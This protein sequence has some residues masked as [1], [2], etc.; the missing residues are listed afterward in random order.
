M[1][2]GPENRFID[3]VHR[4]LKDKCHFEKMHN[5]YRGGTADVW[6]SGPCADI[7]VEYKWRNSVPKRGVAKP[8]LEPLQRDWLRDRYTEG[9]KVFVIIGT[10]AGGI[11]FATPEAWERGRAVSQITIR[12]KKEIAD[13]V[14]DHVGN[15]TSETKDE[16]GKEHK[17]RPNGDVVDLQ[18]RSDVVHAVRVA[19]VRKGKAP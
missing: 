11:I 6:Y 3:S 13:W 18:D 15:Y 17:R 1:S 10:P 12:P 14:R 5:P 8:K 4:Y 7:W 16:G 2:R 19:K 9:R